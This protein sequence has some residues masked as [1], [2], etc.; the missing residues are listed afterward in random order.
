M[1]HLSSCIQNTSSLY[2]SPVLLYTEHFL[3]VWFTCPPVTRTP[4][5]PLQLYSSVCTVVFPLEHLFFCKQNTNVPLVTS[6]LMYTSD[7]PS[8]FP[9]DPANLVPFSL[10]REI[11]SSHCGIITE[12]S[13]QQKPLLSSNN[14]TDSPQT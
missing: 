1:E 13:T 12:W 9:S 7:S 2:G 4:L 6:V 5:F 11:R 8:S 10:F 14:T 3:S